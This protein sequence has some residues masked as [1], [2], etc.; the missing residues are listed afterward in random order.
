M[1]DQTNGSA[2][3][4]VRI[5]D[6]QGL[7]RKAWGDEWLKK[8]KVYECSDGRKYESTDSGTTGIYR[9]L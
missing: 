4:T 8:E 1:A 7:V 2:P 9:P 6:W 3:P 5:I